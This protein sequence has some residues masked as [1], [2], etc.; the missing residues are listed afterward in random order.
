MHHL[1][2]DVPGSRLLAMR[3]ADNVVH[4]WDLATAIGVDPELD[5][6]LVEFVCGYFTPRAESGALYTTGWIAAPARPLP[7]G[8]TSLERLIHLAGR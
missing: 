1:V 4:S 2:G 6:P 3:I 8:A 5:E 7:E